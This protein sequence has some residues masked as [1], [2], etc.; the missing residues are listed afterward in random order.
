MDTQT[1]CET[2]NGIIARKFAAQIDVE[3]IER[4]SRFIAEA[5]NNAIQAAADAL[6]G[7]IAQLTEYFR[8]YYEASRK[9][10]RESWTRP[11]NQRVRPLLIDK[12][13]K[14]YHCRNAI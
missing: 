14:T 13:R 12:R 8:A 11:Q 4:L 5:L 6:N 9:R 10:E 3:T 2:V 7:V 1:L